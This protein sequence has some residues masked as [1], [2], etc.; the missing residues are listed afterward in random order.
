MFNHMKLATKV[1]CGFVV[2]ALIACVIGIVGITK[3]KQIDNADTVLFEMITVPTGD[4]A[5]VAINFQRVRVNS[6]DLI[7]A[8]TPE[9]RANF[10]KRIADLRKQM[11]EKANSFEKTIITEETR[12]TYDEFKQAR[13][14]YGG[15]LE[16][17]A[18]LVKQ[19]KV[20]EAQAI[21]KGEAMAASRNEQNLLEKLM[22][23]KIK[24]GR[25]ISE[26][27]TK[28]ANSATYTMAAFI[29]VGFLLAIGIGVFISRIIKKIINT[30]LAEIKTLVDAAVGGK[31]ATRASAEKINF[32]FRGIATGLNETLDAV[33][34]PMNVAAEYV[35]R[36]SQRRHSAENHRR[37]QRRFQ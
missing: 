34:G 33:I 11:T 30:L 3:I 12:K 13:L 4:L 29:I 23:L 6:R 17:M 10:E 27:N 1:L 5:D 28:I 21:L 18:A 31:L 8:T 15:H 25:T 2:I 24:Q 36:I 19:D 20:G 37:L 9:E 26:D 14:V 35:D 7:Y 16:K 32:E 22:D